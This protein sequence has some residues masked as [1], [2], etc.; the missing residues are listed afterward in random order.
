L[1]ARQYLSYAKT[2]LM[3]ITVVGTAGKSHVE[4]T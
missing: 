2:V 1:S 4:K 3:S